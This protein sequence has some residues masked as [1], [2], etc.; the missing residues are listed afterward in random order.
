MWVAFFLLMAFFMI[1]VTAVQALLSTNSLVEIIQAIPIINSLVTAIL[2][3][4]ALIIFLALLPPILRLM[5]N[6]AGDVSISQIDQ[7]VVSW[8]FIF[9]VVT[10][11]FGSFIAGTFAN[12]FEVLIKNPGNIVTLLGTAAPQ[13]A[14]FFMSFLLARALI[15]TPLGLMRIFGLVMFLIKSRFAAA[16][17]RAKQKLREGALLKQEYGTEIPENTIAALL[18]ITFCI[19]CPIIAPLALLYFCV[20]YL[21]NKYQLMAVARESYQSGGLVWLR[22]FNQ[23]ITGLIIFQITMIGLLGIKKAPV[24]SLLVLPL[25]FI[26]LVFAFI[27]HST[28]WRPMSTLS[29]LTAARRDALEAAEAEAIVQEQREAAAGGFSPTVA[30]VKEDNYLS[31]SFKIE[32]VFLLIILIVNFIVILGV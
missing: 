21:V 5:R 7:G 12:Q 23:L 29:L 13:T 31:P 27:A 8:Y 26:T 20:S 32:Y 30:G 25:P 22:V 6:V 17:P 19:I 9:Q 10:V 1:P 28:F 11:F 18:G 16:S 15:S 24:P 4:L 14:I 2:P 3:G